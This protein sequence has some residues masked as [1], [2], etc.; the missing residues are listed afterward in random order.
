MFVDFIGEG[1]WL[2]EDRLNSADRGEARTTEQH[3]GTW[4]LMPSEPVTEAGSRS[5]RTCST[6][7]GEKDKESIVDS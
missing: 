5:D 4:K 6:F 1:R 3:L 2:K 7:L